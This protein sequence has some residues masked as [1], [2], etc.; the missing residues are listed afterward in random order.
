[1]RNEILEL[2]MYAGKTGQKLK[3]NSEIHVE[4]VELAEKVLVE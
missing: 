3:I 1:M 4:L 2:I